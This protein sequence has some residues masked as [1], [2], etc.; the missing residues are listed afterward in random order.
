[1]SSIIIVHLPKR[2]VEEV[3]LKLDF[4]FKRQLPFCLKFGVL[5][6]LVIPLNLG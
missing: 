2:K 3:Q 6:E 1:M 4:G 5:Q